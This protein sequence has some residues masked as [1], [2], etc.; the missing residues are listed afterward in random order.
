MQEELNKVFPPFIVEKILDYYN[1]YDEWRQKMNAVNEEYHRYFV[2]GR[3][4]Q[5]L[6]KR[7]GCLFHAFNW[8]KWK[9]NTRIYHIDY[10]GLI[11]TE[12]RKY[13]LPKNYY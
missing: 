1:A 9:D 11:N 12:V 13:K 10:L 5:L 4:H 3:E 6:I 2:L 7:A 8:R